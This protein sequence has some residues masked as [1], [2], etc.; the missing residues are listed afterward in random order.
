MGEAVSF[1]SPDTAQIR[2]QIRGVLE[3]YSHDWDVLAELAQNAIDAIVREDPT[4]GHVTLSVNAN[5]RSIEISDNGAGIDPSSLR[6]LLRP[7]GSD[8]PGMPNQIGQKGV[9]LTFVLFSSVDFEI[10]THSVTGS[11]KA[12]IIGAQSWLESETDSDLLVE[13]S[14]IEPKSVRGTRVRLKIADP[15]SALFKL[16]FDQLFFA[17]RTR[18]AL[19]STRFIWE[20]PLNC[21]AKV[22][23]TDLSGNVSE[24][25][26]DCNYLLPIEGLKGDDLISVEGYIDWRQE[27]DRPDAEKRRKLKDKIIYTSGKR[28]Q[29]GRDI[30]FWSCFVPNRATWT[31]L[32]K[33]WGLIDDDEIAD[34]DG[35]EMFLGY[36]FTG[37]LYTSSKGMP[38]GIFLEL[39][40][41]GSAGYFPNFFI[42]IEDPSLSFDI[43][44]KSI[45][46]RQQGMLREIAYEQFR[47]YINEFVKYTSGSIDDPEP[48]YDREELFQE[49]G[50]I[51]NLE[52]EQSRFVKRPNAQE[53]TVAAMFFEQIGKGGFS[54]FSPLI[55]GYRG[56]YDLYGRIGAKSQVVEFKFDLAG[57]FRDFSDERKMFDEVDTVVL[58]EITERD[59]SILSR[60]GLTL[61]EIGAGLLS[62]SSSKFPNA[63]YQLHID[64][65]NSVEIVS[66]K[67]IVKPSE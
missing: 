41:R 43:G 21:D 26:F 65:V 22:T 31:T 57:L 51:P 27:K 34:D 45:Q 44:R 19:G 61:S 9:G 35:D 8:K 42:L 53:A 48:S 54:G 16:S 23:H 64:G 15:E 56:R 18:T 50:T 14:E 67:K 63:H 11:A 6:R 46:G 30:R 17:L 7:F 32:S 49:I 1:L 33:I 62:K 28:Y 47:T 24:R 38:T 59:R 12:K 25:E 58:W 37:G 55:S 20:A 40:P 3:S 5:E 39:K 29:A 60:R 10:E 36:R 52:S 13:I 66:M 4:R 2:H